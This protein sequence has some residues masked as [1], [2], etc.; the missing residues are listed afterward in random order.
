MKT[1]KQMN[2]M[3]NRAIINIKDA[4]YYLEIAIKDAI[5]DTRFKLVK[6]L[7]GKCSVIINVKLINTTVSSLPG[8]RMYIGY[9]DFDV[10]KW[11]KGMNVPDSKTT[12]TIRPS[13]GR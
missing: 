1:M 7:V 8:V 5:I 9:C 12:A 3:I 6:L 13:K 10:G 2:R 4:F 11:S